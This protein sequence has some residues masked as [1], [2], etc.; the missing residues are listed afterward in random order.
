MANTPN[1]PKNRRRGRRGHSTKSEFKAPVSKRQL[2]AAL[3]GVRADMRADKAAS[4]ARA[5]HGW[6]MY[7]RMSKEA[8]ELRALLD[9]AKASIDDARRVSD[10]C[11]KEVLRLEK[12]SA[13]NREWISALCL[14][15]LD[16]EEEPIEGEAEED[17]AADADEAAIQDNTD[18]SHMCAV[19][20]VL[21]EPERV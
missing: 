12:R 1:K 15:V 9:E 10:A 18:Q 3:H 8:Q 11:H 16:L 20:L 7:R 13:K 14:R 6:R 2:R 4:R 19:R 5:D 21:W 17:E